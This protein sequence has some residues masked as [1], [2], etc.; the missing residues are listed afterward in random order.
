VVKKFRHTGML[1]YRKLLKLIFLNLF[2]FMNFLPK[3]RF[4]TTDGLDAIFKKKTKIR[5]DSGLLEFH[6]PNWITHYR[7][8]SILQ[9]EPETLEWIKSMGEGSVLWDVGANVGTFS[10]IAARRNIRVVAI[11]P[12]FMN[13]ELLN[14]N[15]ISNDVAASV[16]ILPFGLG[17][18]TSVLDF[19]MSPQ[20]LTWGGAHNSLGTNIGAGGKSIEN[21]V[22]T[23]ALCFSI[24]HLLEIFKLPT[25]SH[26][27]I[28]VD[29]LELEV[30]KGVLNT[31]KNISSILIEV[32]SE[33]FGHVEGVKEILER[34]S[35]INV[36]SGPD[37]HGSYNQIW[38][39]ASAAN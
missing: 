31:L 38:Q 8:T 36:M 10:V 17:S 21:P 15:V 19:F 20:Y 9:K 33:F 28:D 26:L 5:L 7:A 39:K 27:K 22:R 4:A 6:S 18:K 34:Y 35:F 14:R 37:N 32:D 1:I 24:D 2:N 30:L 11:E 29:G 16:T 25:P 13:I 23:Q 3:G 12:S